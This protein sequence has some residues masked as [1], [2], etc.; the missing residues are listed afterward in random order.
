MHCSRWPPTGTTPN[1]K[2]EAEQTGRGGFETELGAGVE[3]AVAAHATVN[4]YT[5]PPRASVRDGIGGPEAPSATPVSVP[6]AGQL[7][8]DPVAAVARM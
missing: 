3:A 6:P 4:F 8:P 2:E 1:T 7:Q 5:G